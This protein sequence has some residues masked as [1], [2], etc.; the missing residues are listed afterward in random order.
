RGEDTVGASIEGDITGRLIIDG[1][2]SVTGFRYTG[3]LTAAQIEALD[4]DDLL[5]GGP[6][7]R[8]AANVSGGV[9]LDSA[10]QGTDP[11]E[12]DEDGDGVD[13]S[14]ETTANI[15]VFGSAAGLEIGSAT[16]SITLGLVGADDE[17]FGLINRGSIAAS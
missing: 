2:F 5:V 10:H 9:L 16:E 8:I 3:P 4:P 7:V 1:A 11:D 13:D 14:Q 6:A 12:D 15:T 17:A